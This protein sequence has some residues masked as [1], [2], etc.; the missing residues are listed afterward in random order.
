MFPSILNTAGEQEREARSRRANA[1]DAFGVMCGVLFVLWPFCFAWGLLGHAP[2]VSAA[3]RAAMLL[4]FIWAVLGS[5]LWH[6]DTLESLGVGSPR[7]L[8]HA[9]RDRSGADR[10]RIATVFIAVFGGL[11]W[12][13]FADWPDAARFFRLPKSYQVWPESAGQWA[14][15]ALLATCAA[16]IVATCAIRYDNLGSAFG[17]A[18]KISVVF[19][20]YAALAA[21]LARGPAAFAKFELRD[22]SLTVA[23]HIF[24]A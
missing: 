20:A 8:Y 2:W 14:A 3:A 23:A 19:L 18:L 12:F 1:L 16:T 11:L 4:G 22:H 15:I 10:W 17:L 5:P 13:S 9:L 24:R 21:W 7:R 6:R